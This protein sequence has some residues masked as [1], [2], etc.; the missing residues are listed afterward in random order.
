LLH[1]LFEDQVARTPERVAL[2]WEGGQGKFTYEE[3]AQRMNELARRLRFEGVGP[4]VA[5]GVLLERSP[6]MV[7]ALLGVLKAGGFYVPLNPSL[8]RERLLMMLEDARVRILLTVE[9]LVHVVTGIDV[10]TIC[11]DSECGE[12]AEE[13]VIVKKGG[14][15]A[16]PDNLAYVIHTSGSTGRPKGV[17][18]PHGAICNRLLWMQSAYP[19]GVDDS[20]LQKTV[21]NFDASVWELFVPLMTGAKIVLA[22]PEGHQD[23]AYMAEEIT[24]RGVTT[25]Q[26]VPS[27]LRVMLDEPGFAQCRTLKRVFCGG[28]ALPLDLQERF[29][30]TLDADLHNLYGPT[31]VS[32]DA[33]SWDCERGS[34]YGTTHGNVPIG[35]P[36]ANVQIYLLDARQQPVPYG[37][38]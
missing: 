26:L 22:R 31:E 16:T 36:L 7:V 28:E 21:F 37:A 18:I 12:V 14:Q 24:R 34:D 15:L 35:R 30:A 11:L 29:Y 32:I 10:K 23:A 25:L 9:P 1:R 27:M 3:L 4:E 13:D 33:S 38:K 5:V 8:P 17:M 20:V 19:L 6:E 2:E